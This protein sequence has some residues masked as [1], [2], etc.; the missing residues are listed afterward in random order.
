[1]SISL[2]SNRLVLREWLDKDI[3]AFA[4]LCENP[5]VM[6]YLLP[7]KDRAAIDAMARRIGDHLA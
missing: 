5:V 1:M 6:E 7:M 2:K 3:G 4:R